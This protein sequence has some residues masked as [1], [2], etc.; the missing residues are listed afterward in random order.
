MFV[1]INTFQPAFTGISSFFFVLDPK[2]TLDKGLVLS[3]S[4]LYGTTENG[5]AGFPAG[6]VFK[7]TTDGTGYTVLTQFDGIRAADP[8]A[9][10]VLRGSTLYGTTSMG[11][12]SGSY[13]SN[14]G[15]TVFKINTDGS[16]YV[17]LKSFSGTDGDSPWAGLAINTSKLYGTTRNGGTFGNGTLFCLDLAPAIQT[18]TRT[19][20]A[21]TLA[22]GALTGLSYQVQYTTDISSSNWL[23]LGSIVTATNSVMSVSDSGASQRR[24]YR[25]LCKP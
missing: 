13:G 18:M 25:V 10:L 21:F 1:V 16:A 3:G 12:P 6:L 22:W 2:N 14:A 4:T 23:A 15:G 17:I 8:S 11:N 9:G 7:V 20:G 19:N 24:F 5:G